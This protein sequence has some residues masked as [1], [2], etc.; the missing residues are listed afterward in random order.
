[1]SKNDGEPEPKSGKGDN[2]I[3]DQVKIIEAHLAESGGSGRNIGLATIVAGPHG[4][5]KKPVR[6]MRSGHLSN[7]QHAWFNL[8]PG[9]LVIQDDH[10]RGDHVVCVLRITAIAEGQA[11]YELIFEGRASLGDEDRLIVEPHP[12]FTMQNFP[13]QAVEACV[14]KAETYHCREAVYV[15]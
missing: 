3:G 15:A 9:D 10:V 5:R 1:V 12:G 13:T 2:M 7:G 11:T 6:I 4:E 14:R 8:E